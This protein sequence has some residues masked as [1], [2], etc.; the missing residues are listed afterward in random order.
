[1]KEKL[2]QLLETFYQKNEL[3]FLFYLFLF[4]LFFT[5]II[6][7]AV[8]Y[9]LNSKEN[10]NSNMSLES[11]IEQIQGIKEEEQSDFN[12]PQEIVTE[13]AGAVTSPGVY[14]LKADSRI[15]DLVNQANGF[16]PDASEIW[17]SRKLNLAQNLIDSQKIYI[18]FKWED[19]AQPE[20]LS[21]ELATLINKKNDL[22]EAANGKTQV[23]DSKEETT[24]QNKTNLNN[25]SLEDLQLLS[26]IGPVYAENIVK[27][28]P[29]KNLDE[30]RTKSGIPLSTIDKIEDLITF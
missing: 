30:F 17:I 25:S 26:G 2:K 11:G 21:D 28:R 23:V 4:N 13:I 6:S 10:I 1:M 24:E 27:N 14:K 18:P 20:N 16:S 12:K 7:A 29:Y 8:G 15:I 5:T 9:Y 3:M 22:E 19:I